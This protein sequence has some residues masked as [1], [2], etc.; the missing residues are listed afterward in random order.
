MHFS[1]DLVGVRGGLGD[2][3]AGDD[4]GGLPRSVGKEGPGSLYCGVGQAGRVDLVSMGG[5]LGVGPRVEIRDGRVVLLGAINMED[6]VGFK[7]EGEVG[8]REEHSCREGQKIE[9][10][11]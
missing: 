1:H 4:G 8:G 11:L 9:N 3:V 7:V 10:K 5:G 6:G 2:T